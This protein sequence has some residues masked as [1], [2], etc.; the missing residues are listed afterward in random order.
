METFGSSIITSKKR[1]KRQRLI[2]GTQLELVYETVLLQRIKKLPKVCTKMIYQLKESII[3]K[4]VFIF[5]QTYHWHYRIFSSLVY[6]YPPT[7]FPL[8]KLFV[9]PYFSIQYTP[10]PN[11]CH[12]RPKEFCKNQCIFCE[13]TNMCVERIETFRTPSPCDKG[14]IRFSH[15]KHQKGF[16]AETN[17]VMPVADLHIVWW[18]IN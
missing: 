13:D 14:I 8:K 1:R 9:G 18:N 6:T 11:R 3:I 7:L 17:P 15:S 2:Q 4:R 10:T 5:H 12:H 16:M